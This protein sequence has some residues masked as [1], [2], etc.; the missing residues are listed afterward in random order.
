PDGS[1]A[2]FVVRYDPDGNV[3]WVTRLG[4]TGNQLPTAVAVDSMGGIVVAGS[5]NSGTLECVCSPA[6]NSGKSDG[7]L[8]MLTPEGAVVACYQFGD[9][10]D[11]IV[12]SLAVRGN[13]I[14]FGGTM[15]G[16]MTLGTSVL[17]SNGDSDAF[18][19]TVFQ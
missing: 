18:V 15:Y 6:S 2:G 19:A 9:D 5:V 4:G 13:R 7:F 14:A 16:T 17:T 10:Q 3:R 12:T 1:T 8:A 11:Q